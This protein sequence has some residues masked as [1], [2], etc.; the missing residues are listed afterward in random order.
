MPRAP[1]FAAALIAG[2]SYAFADRVVDPGPLQWAWKGAG[3]GLLA[4]WAAMQSRSG[5][6]RL[7]AIGMAIYA[8]ADVL[9]NAAGAVPGG[10]AFAIGHGVMIALYRR[11]RR[12][13][14]GGERAI[15]ALLLVAVPVAAF[16]LPERRGEA[17]QVAVYAAVV[18]AMAAA[19]LASRFRRDRVGLGALMFLVSDLLIFARMGPLAH[20]AIPGLGIWP[21]Y[22]AG[23]ALMARGVAHGLAAGGR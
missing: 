15:L 21:L 13:L 12:R 9:L 17:V 11:N 3:V 10:A 6:G 8:I 23:Q 2:I 4:L 19:A 16:L 20:S 7:L 1:L 18:G 22:F 14:T 5:D